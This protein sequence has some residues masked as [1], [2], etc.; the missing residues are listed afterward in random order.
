[1]GMEVVAIR[2]SQ[3]CEMPF[4]K[5]PTSLFMTGDGRHVDQA[6]GEFKKI[7]KNPRPDARRKTASMV[8]KAAAQGLCVTLPS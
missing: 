4:Y 3:M 2:M 8:G 1:M 5:F 7:H 6:F